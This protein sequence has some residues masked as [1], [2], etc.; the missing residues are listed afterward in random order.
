[1]A[2]Q[3]IATPRFYIDKISWLANNGV[4][5]H[6]EGVEVG[7]YPSRISAVAYT[8]LQQG[9]SRQC[10]YGNVIVEDSD[11]LYHPIVGFPVDTTFN[12][13]AVLGHNWGGSSWNVGMYTG[14]PNPPHY[15]V[16]VD[17]NP[18]NLTEIVN[19]G[20]NGYNISPEKDGFSIAEF[21]YSPPVDSSGNRIP[22]TELAIIQGN[23]WNE[24]T[25]TGAFLWGEYFNMPQSPESL[26]MSH[27]YDGIYKQET[28]GGSTLTGASYYKPPKWGALEA[29]QLGGQYRT[30]S[31]RRVWDLKFD[32]L[33]DDDLE[34]KHYH[35]DSDHDNWNESGN[36]FTNV[37]HYTNGGQLPFIFCPDPS[38]PYEIDSWTMPEF[39]VC[40]FDM[41][42]FK[43]VQ[44]ANGIYNIAVKLKEVW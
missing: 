11:G 29:W 25:T 21:S 43:R 33:S 32:Y 15:D 41:K 38:I 12:F 35:M 4:S 23:D 26:T 17:L 7:I 14:D 20:S 37:I 16:P 27:E 10:R 36:W 42:T 31:G 19:W 9:V 18:S 2:N 30:Y 22:L 13:V 3:N 28:A 40:K 34:P 44:V 39:A 1:M 8:E 5:M 24:S 6:P